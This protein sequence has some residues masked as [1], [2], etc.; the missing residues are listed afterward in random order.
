MGHIEDR[1]FRVTD[2]GKQPTPRRGHGRRWRARYIDTAGRERSESFARRIDAERFLATVEAD[3]LRGVY[4][5][6]DAGRVT[7]RRYA[8]DWLEGQTFSDST[9]EATELRLRLHVF[10]YL[11]DRHLAGIQPS[12]VQGWLRALQ[13]KLAPTYVRVVR[14]NLSAVLSAA[15]DDGR[16]PR[17]PCRAASVRTPK[18]DVRR[19]EPWTRER[20][21]AVTEALPEHYRIMA[22][23]AA[24]CGLRQGEVF[25]LAVDDVDFLRGF[26]RVQRQVKIL[27]SRLVL[28]PPK[29]GRTRE[30]PLGESV[31]LAL[32]AH[33]AAYPAQSVELPWERTD[34]P[35]ALASLVLTSREGRALNRNYVNS[36]LWKPALEAAGVEP[37][38][39]NGM[40]ALRHWFASVLLDAG[41]SIKAVS[42][43]LG[44]SDAGFTLRT[45]THLMPSSDARTRRAVDRALAGADDGPLADGPATAQ[46]GG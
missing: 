44:H 23:L 10:P 28:A 31:A 38:R 5:D 18:V 46:R 21:N 19:V 42:Q 40:H 27:G 16:I 34:G 33:L 29:G 36:F 1:W 8:N 37:V 7:L 35:P 30:V 4:V 41:E 17:N 12:H 11:G 32:S 15:V 22:T 45:Y 39:A 2:D 26:V 9:R 43:Y 3:K 20:V 14:A 13:Q 6:P 25:G 24:G